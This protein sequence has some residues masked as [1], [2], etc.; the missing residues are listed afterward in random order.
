MEQG[1]TPGSS[2]NNL[3]HGT[4]RNNEAIPEPDQLQHSE[5]PEELKEFSFPHNQGA[6]N[7][8]IVATDSSQ[9]KGET[10]LYDDWRTMMR[11]S[12][13]HIRHSNPASALT[14]AVSALEAARLLFDE[15]DSRLAET[16]ERLATAYEING[17]LLH[18]ELSLKFAI[19]MSKTSAP[20][21]DLSL[22]KKLERLGR[23][24]ML[25]PDTDAAI[26]SFTEAASIRDSLPRSNRF[27]DVESQFNLGLLHLKAGN[28]SAGLEIIEA[29]Y[30]EFK[31]IPFSHRHQAAHV[32]HTAGKKITALGYPELAVKVFREALVLLQNGP[33]RDTAGCADL[34]HSLAVACNAAGKTDTAWGILRRG[35]NL[36]ST[37][38]P[39][40]DRRWQQTKNAA[41]L[42]LETGN[43]IDAEKAI[44]GF[45]RSQD[46][47]SG[48]LFR[49]RFK[50]TREEALVSLARIQLSAGLCTDAEEVL[51]EL[52]TS[53]KDTDP[54][55]VTLLEL[56][57]DDS[58]RIIHYT[59]LDKRS[60]S[61]F[62]AGLQLRAALAAYAGESEISSKYLKEVFLLD[63]LRPGRE[64]MS[65]ACAASGLRY[66]RS[67]SHQSHSTDYD[68]VKERVLARLPHSDVA[69]SAHISLHR[70]NAEEAKSI[71]DF[72]EAIS[73]YDQAIRFSEKTPAPLSR[74]EH[75][76]LL[77]DFATLLQS[78]GDYSGCHELLS[79]ADL[80]IENFTRSAPVQIV[81]WHALSESFAHFGDYEKAE[82]YQ[83]HAASVRNEL[84]LSNEKPYFQNRD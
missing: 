61:L 64:V 36:V 16:H 41:E 15:R 60:A 57:L 33:V 49:N 66:L 58:E 29:S 40:S 59:G 7:E 44:R 8:K 12:G 69:L 14:C 79:K 74:A 10:T 84:S 68:E 54:L 81:V 45:M 27:D 39:L 4:R 37:T 78:C 53:L 9:E 21:E 48:P 70:L 56:N 77:V 31:K 28:D 6:T 83:R 25:I 11:L 72:A 3:S 26:V 18:S 17:K 80:M 42:F 20:V 55:L 46:F 30:P 63:D 35:M 23:L 62:R 5:S 22:A 24:Q 43:A 71:G 73:Q 1:A 51:A 50:N 34:T 32:L 2:D 38:P 76:V 19:E 47:I 52:T 82:L 67:I 65:E 13:Y 75:A